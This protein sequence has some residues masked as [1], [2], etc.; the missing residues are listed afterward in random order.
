MFS[1][2]SQMNFESIDHSVGRYRLQVETDNLDQFKF[3]EQMAQNCLDKK[4]EYVPHG[5]W[6][7]VNQD[8]GK[9]SNCGHIVHTSFAFHPNYCEECGCKMDLGNTKE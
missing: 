8:H 3:M 2:N 4:L 6:Y 1:W 9:C 5:C 7:F